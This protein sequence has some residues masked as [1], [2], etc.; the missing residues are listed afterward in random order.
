MTLLEEHA[1]ALN[2]I[3]EL[4]SHSTLHPQKG[5]REFTCNEARNLPVTQLSQEAARLI[6]ELENLPNVT[7]LEELL[8]RFNCAF[9]S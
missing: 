5:V 3:D 4:M 8:R 9:L 2:V 1:L 7:I 6:A